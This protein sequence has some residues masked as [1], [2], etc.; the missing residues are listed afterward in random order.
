MRSESH[1]LNKR[2]NCLAVLACSFS[3]LCG[4]LALGQ[5]SPFPRIDNPVEETDNV[6][7]HCLELSRI[8]SQTSTRTTWSILLMIEFPGEEPVESLATS[9]IEFLDAQGELIVVP[10]GEGSSSPPSGGSMIALEQFTSAWPVD[11]PKPA[12]TKRTYIS[13]NWFCHPIPA[14]TAALRL[15]F[16]KDDSPDSISFRLTR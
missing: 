12:N 1:F 13:R 11:M 15:H 8:A 2:L 6:R 10:A 3:S 7:V 5:E 4:E 14:E 16:G 9:N